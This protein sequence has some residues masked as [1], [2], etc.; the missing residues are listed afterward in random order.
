MSE[1]LPNGW[2]ETIWT[3]AVEIVERHRGFRQAVGNGVPW[4]AR[5]D[6]AALSW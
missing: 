1:K 5:T 6:A 4:K 3:V 2:V